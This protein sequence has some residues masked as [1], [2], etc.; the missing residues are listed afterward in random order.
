MTDIY[1]VRHGEAA[2]SWEHD[3]DPGLSERGVLQAQALTD[4]FSAIPISTIYSSPLS[5]ARQTALSLSR[6]RGIDI[7]VCDTY[8]EIPTPVNIPL[9]DRLSWLRSCAHRPWDQAEPELLQWRRKI[10]DSLRQLPDQAVVFTHFMVMNAVLGEAR[11]AP[12][13]VCYQPDYCSVLALQVDDALA[14]VDTGSESASRV[15]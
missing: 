15:L 12:N 14:V 3:R 1:L 2:A 13:L 5:R 6:A 9:S 10:L 7:H 11:G 4:Y 8:R